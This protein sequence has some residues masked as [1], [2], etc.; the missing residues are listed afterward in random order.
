[1]TR[2]LGLLWGAAILAASLAVPVE[3]TAASGRA[4]AAQG[5]TTRLL[6]AGPMVGYSTMQEVA[7][8]AQTAGPSR[9]HAVYWD[10][11]APGRRY[12][13]NGVTTEAASAFTAHL[14]ADSVEPGR[15]YRYEL[16]VDGQEVRRDYP[17]QF[18]TQALWQWR[19]G[20]PDFTMALGSCLYVNEPAY[21][22]PGAPYGSHYRILE[23]IHR[24]DPDLM[25]WLGDNT[26]L[27]EVDWNSR[28]GILHRYGHTRALSE[29][30]PLLGSVHHYAT[31]DDHDFGP[32]NS[33]RSFW[34]KD[35]TLEA[36]RLFWANPNYGVHG[37]KGITG[38]FGWADVRFFLLDNRTHRTPNARET[39]RRTIL[40]EAQLQWLVDALVSTRAT[41]KVVVMG[42]QFLTSA[43]GSEHY[44]SFPRERQRILE[45]LRE[46]GVKGVIFLSGNPHFTE[47]SRLE[48]PGT[49]PLYDLTVSPLTAGVNDGGSEVANGNRVPGTVV[50][51]HNF[52]LIR[53]HG[54]REDRRL[55]ITIRDADGTEHWTR[56]ITAAE[57]GV[58]EA[59]APPWN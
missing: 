53:V 49:Y 20:P 45:A 50:T 52:G 6:R 3:S 11:A 39:G 25:L 10:T 1:M 29:L 12:R 21:D 32:N 35:E 9:V 7:L 22:R 23:A 46:E 58:E 24:A 34:M 31:W 47:L 51:R 54:P 55:T 19:R 18:Q 27:R 2:R 57:L 36:F 5:D 59:P 26:Y 33:D 13:T 48:R 17:L 28:S 37:G 42:G 41:F 15:V 40:G 4:A 14:V 16:V 38:T 44:V 43:S 8:W 30:Q 56:T